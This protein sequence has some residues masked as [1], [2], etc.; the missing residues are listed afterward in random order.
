[1]SVKQILMCAIIA[2]I[3]FVGIKVLQF[4][5]KF[6]A[7]FISTKTEY[8]RHLT[9]TQ[10]YTKIYEEKLQSITLDNVI[11]YFDNLCST[12]EKDESEIIL[13][14]KENCIFEKNNKEKISTLVADLDDFS[15]IYLG[16]ELMQFKSYIDF[17]RTKI[18]LSKIVYAYNC[19]M[20]TKADGE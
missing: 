4:V 13:F 7:Y 15:R 17:A 2:L 19:A 6:T 5:I 8:N 11:D 3:I 10:K 16:G 1:M 18:F 12:A 9:L 14:I 20:Q